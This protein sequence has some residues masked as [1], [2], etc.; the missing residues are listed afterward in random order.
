MAESKRRGRSKGAGRSK[1]E[2][3]F[4]DRLTELQNA[5]RA[6]EQGELTLDESL[7]AYERGLGL[8]KTCYR[9][10]EQAERRIELLTRGE[11]GSDQR[12]DFKHEAWTSDEGEDSDER[13]PD[14]DPSLFDQA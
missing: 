13:E 9:D 7:E 5:L 6:L 4:E 12:S 3:G 8:L 2:P 14:D 11:D 1:D 10:L